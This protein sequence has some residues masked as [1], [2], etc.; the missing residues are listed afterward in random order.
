M[1]QLVGLHLP[2]ELKMGTRLASNLESS[3]LASSQLSVE[4]VDSEVARQI[5]D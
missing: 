1:F 5:V 4:A 2:P 3:Q